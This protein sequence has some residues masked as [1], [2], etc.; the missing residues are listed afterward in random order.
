MLYVRDGQMQ[1]GGFPLVRGDFPN[2]RQLDVIHALGQLEEGRHRRIGE[3]QNPAIR[4]LFEEVAADGDCTSQV[5]ETKAVLRID[6]YPRTACAPHR[7]PHLPVWAE[8][9]CLTYPTCAVARGWR[10]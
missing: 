10:E 2:G 3:Q 1:T 7:R 9:P 4:H 6:S 5:A 8:C